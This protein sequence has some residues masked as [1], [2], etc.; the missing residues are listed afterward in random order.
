MHCPYSSIFV[1]SDKTGFIHNTIGSYVKQW[2]VVVE[3]LNFDSYKFEN[4]VSTIQWLF[5]K[6]EFNQVYN[7]LRKMNI[8][9]TGSYAT[10][11]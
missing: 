2:Y 7:F 1:V 4:L 6:F 3:N 10:S 9:S 11:N 5:I 8:L